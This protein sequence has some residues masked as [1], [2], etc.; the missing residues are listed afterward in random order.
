MLKLTPIVAAVALLAAS[1]AYAQQAPDPQAAQAVQVAQASEALVEAATP[2]DAMP[3]DSVQSYEDWLADFEQRFGQTIGSAADGRVFYAGMAVISGD[4]AADPHYGTQLALAY[5]RAM[6]D[7]QADFILQNYGRLKARTVRSLFDDLSSDKDAFDPVELQKAA[8][9]GG[10]RLEALFDKALVLVDKKLDSALAEEGVPPDEIQKMSV[11][12]KK[13]LY[14]DTLNKEMIKSA[15]QS[16]QGLVPVQTRIFPIQENNKSTMAVAVI[17]VQSEKTRQFAKDIARKRPSLVK[18]TPRAIQDLL[19]A[20]KKGYLDEI[21]LRFA[22]DAAGR[23]M[24]LAYGRTSVPMEPGWS[25]SRAVRAKQNA[26]SIAQSLAE[27]NIVEFMNTNIQVSETTNVGDINEEW[28]KQI[29]QIDNGKPGEVQQIKERISET[30]QK[31]VKSGKA[32][33]VGE[34]RGSSVLKRWDVKDGNGVTHVGVVVGW[35]YDQLD[36]ANAIEAQARGKTGAQLSGAQGA[37]SDQSRASKV[38]NNKND[39]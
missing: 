1:G 14:K 22:Y 26:Q 12:Q 24:L 13:N 17:A 3:A 6:F 5:E 10:S 27:A 33:A 23:P 38:I 7:M 37:A 31:I 32:Q 15:Y 34:L 8:A 19:P 30:T 21:G 18:G 9:D 25:A 29:T 11:E 2:A 16:M 35:T 28:A 39:F 20:D 36:N 4:N